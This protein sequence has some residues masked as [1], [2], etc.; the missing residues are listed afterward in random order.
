MRRSN[1][2]AATVVRPAEA[3]APVGARLPASTPTDVDLTWIE[4]R[5]E[6]Q[7]RFGRAVAERAGGPHKRIVS[8]RPGS[9]FGL[10]GCTVNDLGRIF[11]SLAIVTAVAP[12]AP[13]AT[14]P[15]I[16]PGGDILLR[17]DDLD[18]IRAVCREIDMIEASGVDLC[19]VSPDHWRHIG[20][21]LAVRLPFRAY[22]ADRHAAWLRRRELEA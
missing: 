1:V 22:G 14:H 21:R 17:L 16:A 6:Q 15:G 5:L 9:T 3:L 11:W 4:G 7:L 10:I 8:F 2:P 12:G 13:F 19:D 20:S 18:E